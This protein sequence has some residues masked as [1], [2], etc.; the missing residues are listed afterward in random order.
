[1]KTGLMH[2]QYQRN[3]NYLT[4]KLYMPRGKRRNNPTRELHGMRGTRAYKAWVNMRNRCF[5]KSL[6][7]YP[8]YGGRGITVCARWDSFLN[9]FTDMGEQPEGLTLERI[10][11]NGN[12]EPSN[13]KWATRAEQGRNTRST[14]FITLNGKTLCLADWAVELGVRENLL[15]Q[16]LRL[17]WSPEDVISIPVRKKQMHIAHL[18]SLRGKTGTET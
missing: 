10:D 5:S 13:C 7:E 3:R 9:F 6:R 4:W 15:V 16:R 17:G 1:M 12:Y 11:N 14:R 2:Y 18:I 8:L